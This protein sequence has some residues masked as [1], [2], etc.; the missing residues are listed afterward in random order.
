M[1]SGVPAQPP[2]SSFVPLRQTRNRL[3]G[4]GRVQSTCGLAGR[5]GSQAGQ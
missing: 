3:R 1:M 5:S 2:G 4:T